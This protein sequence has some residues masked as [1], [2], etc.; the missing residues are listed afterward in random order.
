V[1]RGHPSALDIL[2]RETLDD[3]E[4]IITMDTDA[5]PV[6]DGW[7]EQLTDLIAEGAGVSGIYRDEFA[8]RIR[9]FIH[10]SCLCARRQDLLAC[11]VSFMKGKGQDVGQNLSDILSRDHPMAPLRRSNARN[12]HVLLGGLYGDL[13]YHHGAGSRRARFWGCADREWNERVR[14][15]L[16]DA[17][18]LDL[19]HLIAVLRGECEDDFGLA[20]MP[21]ATTDLPM[22]VNDL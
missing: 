14:T 2:V 16:R 1:E 20:T 18:F 19:S 13:V 3:V 6:R 9:P 10:L 11:G 7:I 15:T 12:L 5:F 22:A 8:P 17:A 4:Y 21:R